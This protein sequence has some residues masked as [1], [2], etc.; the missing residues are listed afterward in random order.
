MKKKDKKRLSEKLNHRKQLTLDNINYSLH[1][2]DLLII[3]ISGAGIYACLETAK[4]IVEKGK[5]IMFEIQFPTL[6]FVVAIVANLISQYTGYLS[7]KYDYCMCEKQINCKSEIDELSKR[8]IKNFDSKSQIF[9]NITNWLNIISLAL[10][11]LGLI[12]LMIF[13]CNITF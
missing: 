13:F 6:L 2:L 5:T 11:I 9:D 3:S 7:N 10:L 8:E 1:R 12:F 4:F